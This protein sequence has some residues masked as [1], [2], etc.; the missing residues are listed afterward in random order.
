MHATSTGCSAA[1][2]WTWA[3]LAGLGLLLAYALPLHAPP[4]GQALLLQVPGAPLVERLFPGV[5]AVWIVARLSCLLLGATLLAASLRRWVGAADESTTAAAPVEAPHDAVGTLVVAGVVL[6]LAS[7]GSA[8]FSHGGQL[9]FLAC[10]LLVPVA[11]SL[12]AAARRE[13][14]ARRDRVSAGG[15]LGPVVLASLWLLHRLPEAYGSWLLA[16]GIDYL[17]S[18]PCYVTAAAED[19]LVLTDGCWP[20]YTMG[21]QVLHGLGVLG[22][23]GIPLSLALVQSVS[24]FWTAASAALLGAVVARLGGTACALVATSV[25]L[26][27]P[28]ALLRPVVPG[29]PVQTTFLVLLVWI[30]LS[31]RRRPGPAAA[32]GFGAL[33]G[34][35]ALLPN[36][37]VV[38]PLFAL[39]MLPLWRRRP[40]LAAVA[41]LFFLA[42]FAPGSTRLPQMFEMARTQA[43]ASLAWAPLEAF[44]L[45]RLPP[46]LSETGARMEGNAALDV[47]A[48]LAL[49]PVAVAR[50]STRL[51]GD[52][53]IEPFGAALATVGVLFALLTWRVPRSRA[54]VALFVAAMLPGLASS[55][56]RVMASRVELLTPMALLAAHGW[57]L[58]G[59][60][61]PVL[62]SSPLAGA[63]AAA[64]IAA[65]GTWIF[66]HVQ[67][68]LLAPSASGLAARAGAPFGHDLWWSQGTLAGR[69]GVEEVLGNEWIGRP[70]RSWDPRKDDLSR[71]TAEGAGFFWT[72]G[73]QTDRQVSR[74][75]CADHPSHTLHEVRGGG[76][77]TRLFAALREP[78]PLGGADG[79]VQWIPRSCEETL[80]TDATDATRALDVAMRLARLGRRDEAIEVLRGA[81]RRTLVQPRL[82][83]PLATL[84]LERNRRGDRQ[85]ALF[86]A[87][88]SCRVSGG[89]DARSC[90]LASSVEAPVPSVPH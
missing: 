48:G 1:R 20:G 42:G 24:A 47:A 65:S 69:S 90:L 71:V 73:E 17:A 75:V 40:R 57:M 82:H 44:Y 5:P 64:V 21:P 52:A 22:W 55:Y 6:C 70:L 45:G 27:S 7:W 43:K 81:A 66:D 56:D 84:L 72:P 16:D 86:W 76:G 77:R 11:A 36:L 29:A 30:G 67:P 39:W 78:P 62:T 12:A 35:A 85:E 88:H 37:L 23:N 13:P 31:L 26:W 89:R 87:R 4:A 54:L 74:E 79:A 18:Y 15:W 19:F 60:R 80:E 10:L 61:W 63:A 8:R 2:R 83:H 28:F 41:L 25:F 59:A 53:M 68:R 49:A 33:L 9:L 34:L 50:A 38:A 32:A 3:E 46:S 14:S 58:L 51:W